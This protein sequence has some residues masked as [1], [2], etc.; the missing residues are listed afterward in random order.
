MCNSIKKYMLIIGILCFSCISSYAEGVVVPVDTTSQTFTFYDISKLDTVKLTGTNPS[1]EFYIPI[2]LHWDA[3]TL[4]I[5]LI[6]QFSKILNASSSLT[7]MV[8][9]TPIDTI[10]LD[11]KIEQPILWK[12]KI[13]KSYL[14]KKLITLRLVGDM[15][16]SDDICADRDNKGNWVTFSANSSVTYHY[17][18]HLS[19]LNLAQFPFPFI[20]KNAPYV[21]MI[22]LVIP[23]QLNAKLFGP[24]FMMAN[25]LSHDASWRGV[26]FD[27]KPFSEF[28]QKPGTH[29]SILIGKPEHYDFSMFGTPENVTL[30]A[31]IWGIHQTPLSE[32][33]GVIWLTQYKNL[34]LLV[35][36]ANKLKGIRS[37]LGS[38]YSK[39]MNY[40]SSSAD[41]F[42]AQPQKIVEKAWPETKII[43]FNE[44]GYQDSVVFGSGENQQI[45]QFNLPHEYANN[46]VKL[47]LNYS[48]S[49]FLQSDRPSSLTVSINDIP[50]GGTALKPDAA[51]LNQ[52]EV[53]LPPEQL[54][55][56]QNTLSVMFTLVMQD[57][58]CSRDYLSQVWGTIYANS[59]LEFHRSNEAVKNQLKH[60]SQLTDGTVLLTLPEEEGVYRDVTLLNKMIQFA[61]SFKDAQYLEVVTANDILIRGIEHD[62]VSLVTHQDNPLLVARIQETLTKLINSLN[63]ASSA[64]LKSIDSSIFTHAFNQEQNVGFA[65]IRLSEKNGIYSRLTLYGYSANDLGIVLSLMNNQDKRHSLSGDLVVAF[66]NGT[67]TSLSTEE[68]NTL[69]TT[70]ATVAKMSRLTGI[71]FISLFCV[72]AILVIVFFIWRNRR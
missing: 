57:N 58:V 64:M 71:L 65:T 31:G 37:A 34:P 40:L 30:N 36:S 44:L 39:S 7:A 70:E 38:I 28:I 45:Y 25:L 26:R 56:G 35:I 53:V 2:P 68:I 15:R 27:I 19:G 41:V 67:F 69:V 60:Y 55:I 14:N 17:Q 9:N 62:S 6:V 24:Y 50:I 10:K 72:L 21:D 32:E 54:K 61:T 1:Y 47:I 18:L 43:S 13:P 46:P 23:D 52:L 59:F 49:P 5:S 8:G 51:Q 29:P 66:S 12:F 33:D 42:V 22:T 16:I 4:D 48:H 11:S 63:T 3:N 20:Q